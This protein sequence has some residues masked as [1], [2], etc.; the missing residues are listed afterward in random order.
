MSSP[1]NKRKARTFGKLGSAIAY[2]NK[3]RERNL[4]HEIRRIKRK[5]DHLLA[6]SGLLRTPSRKKILDEKTGSVLRVQERERHQGVV[7]GGQRHKKL[8][9]HLVR[10][11]G[12]LASG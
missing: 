9:E 5:I 6:R 7:K 10:L 4:E 11:E 2:N 12:Q 8:E 3:R 1:K